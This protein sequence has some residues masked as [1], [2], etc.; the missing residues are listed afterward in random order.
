MRRRRTRGAWRVAGGAWRYYPLTVLRVRVLRQGMQLCRAVAAAAGRH[1]QRSRCAAFGGKGEGGGTEVRD[2]TMTA[3]HA[4]DGAARRARNH[5]V[6]R[7]QR[8]AGPCGRARRDTVRSVAR[9]TCAALLAPPLD[10]T[11]AL[12]CWRRRTAR[13]RMNKWRRPDWAA[14][15]GALRPAPF[16]PAWLCSAPPLAVASVPALHF[17][18]RSSL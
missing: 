6:S 10:A 11:P 15:R 14:R 17:S 12:V 5:N 18:T 3:H 1:S 13:H 7:G 4:M 2:A 9:V 16:F 8:A